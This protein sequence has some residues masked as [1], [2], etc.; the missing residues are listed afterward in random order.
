MIASSPELAKALRNIVGHEHVLTENDLTTGYSVDWTGRFVGSTPIVVRP[1]STEQTASVV[2][3]LN[4]YSIPLIP[5]GGNTGL[6]GGSIPM[7]GEVLLSLKRLNTIE[8]VDGLALQL[9]VG[10][11]ATLAETQEHVRNHNFEIGVDLA[12]RDSC[13]IGGMIATNAGGINVLRYGAMRE[14]LIGVE[15]VMSDGTVIKHL[16]GLEK[17][18]TGYHLPSLLAGSEGTLAVITKARLRLRPRLHEKVTALIAFESVHDAVEVATRLRKE[19]PSLHALEAIFSS[20]MSLVSSHIGTQVPIGPNGNAW[21]LVE[22]ASGTDPFEEFQQA[23]ENCDDVIVDVAVAIDDRSR[24]KLWRFREQITEAI[25]VIGTPHKLDITIGLARLEKFINEIP[26]VVKHA[27]P[28]SS[29]YLFGHLGDGNVHVNVLGKDGGEPSN[30]VESAV[31]SYVASL[32][33]SISAENGIGTAKKS[34]LHLNRTSDELRF[35]RNI[36]R[37]LDPNNIMH[38]NC[39]LSD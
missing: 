26:E 16:E 28:N 27:D 29:T 23:L 19:L 4:K 9:T 38:P 17:D 10:A 14:Q 33:G 2:K 6:V 35:F 22:V 13:T 20:A 7:S 5:Q 12:A 32:G 30:I 1:G 21:L 15:A 3:L 37:A 18:N 25:A 39:L 11:G 24:G 8:P 31:L 36:K 34:Y